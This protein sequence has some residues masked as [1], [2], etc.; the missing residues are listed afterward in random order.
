MWH[1][2]KYV[3]ATLSHKS[4]LF[5]HQKPG[6]FLPN[7]R[8]FMGMIH[9]K[10]IPLS[11][12]VPWRKR[13]WCASWIS[14]DPLPRHWASVPKCRSATWHGH[15]CE[16]LSLDIYPTY[17]TVNHQC[18]MVLSCFYFMGKGTDLGKYHDISWDI[19]GMT[20]KKLYGSMAI[21]MGIGG[22]PLV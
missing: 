18:S 17:A 10:P 4:A 2:P 6:G 1:P 9:P 20:T 13:S 11:Q 19:M 5:S 8:H 14:L 21:P 7:F 16:F 15:G 22:K 12:P 3:T